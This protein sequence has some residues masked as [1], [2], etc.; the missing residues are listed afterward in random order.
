M[1]RAAAGVP[2]ARAPKFTSWEEAAAAAALGPV[3]FV[4]HVCGRVHR[5]DKLRGWIGCAGSRAKQ[6]KLDILLLEG[7]RIGLALP[8]VWAE[9]RAPGC[10]KAWDEHFNRL[11]TDPVVLAAAP[12]EAVSREV[13]RTTEGR[14]RRLSEI[15]G[16]ALAR[17]AVPLDAAEAAA[18]ALRQA[19]LPK[20]V[21]RLA[22][23]S[24]TAIVAWEVAIP[25]G[26]GSEPG[27][28]I[29]AAFTGRQGEALI[30]AA[31]PYPV[32]ALAGAL[33]PAPPA[34]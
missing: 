21:R 1:G 7:R 3:R 5:S 14:W 25:D 29:R 16:E 2:G 10:Q 32:R 13:Q 33:S 20:G 9:W 11:E 31:G 6:S 34:P 30:L 15:T 22:R 18:A 23:E 12:S 4:C 28:W 27:S 24:W 26:P 8:P 17:A 19:A